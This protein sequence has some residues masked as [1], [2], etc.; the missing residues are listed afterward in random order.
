M[1]MKFLEYF[2]FIQEKY[3]I[4][5]NE[6]LEE[7]CRSN[8]SITKSNLSHKLN[9]DRKINEEELNVFI[10]VIRPSIA[11]EEKL[12]DLFK[13]YL[14]GEAE[15][16]EVKLIKEYI[17][18]F[19]DNAT[20]IFAERALKLD[21]ISEIN[22]EKLLGEIVFA[23]LSD[24]WSKNTIKILCQPEY[25]KMIDT[26][27]YLSGIESAKV[28]HIVCFN[29]D[30]KSDSNIY[31]IHC[32][33]TLD[34]LAIKN[35]YHS[36]RYFYDKVNA[37]A[38][39]L[40]VFP[41]FIVT[42]ERVL[43]ISHDFKSG[44]LSSEKQLVI[45]LKSEFDRIYAQTQELFQIINNDIEYIQMCA[46]IEKKTQKEFFTLQFHPCVLFNYDAQIT[47]SCIKDEFQ[48]KEELFDVLSSRW[49]G[50][51][52]IK[53]YHVHSPLGTQDFM[54]NGLTT[55]M[56]TDIFNP[57]SKIDR[58]VVMNKIRTNVEQ[59]EIEVSERFIKIPRLLSIA[60]YDSGTVLISYKDT[61]ESRLIVRERSLYKSMMNFFKYVY[62]FETL[63]N[64]KTGR[65]MR[66]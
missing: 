26:L 50:L 43:L 39:V 30:Y 4:P 23:L 31:N 20:V 14:F 10:D 61:N 19:D 13:I 27:I 33:R 60:C 47:K 7:L 24:S 51:N 62:R 3:Q 46:E 25:R 34:K 66:V 1:K 28:E 45:K 15:F 12:R 48:Y 18:Q 17:E 41:F 9:G 32:L 21:S 56:S 11:E 53:G 59:V 57:V 42:D 35:Q 8:I 29:N 63:Q 64:K 38:N 37:R 2:K 36:I 40:T 55:D 65:M 49:S 58:N 22:D 52:N 16:E 6:L 44:Y 5:N 54:E